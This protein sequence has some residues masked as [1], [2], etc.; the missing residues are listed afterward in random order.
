[1][2]TAATPAALQLSINRFELASHS[3]AMKVSYSPD[4]GPIVVEQSPKTPFVYKGPEGEL[5]FTETQ[6]TREDTPMGSLWSVVLT[7]SAAGSTTLS[8]FLPPI[9]GNGS[10]TITTYAVRTHKSG[11]PV[12]VGAGLT[13]EVERLKGDAEFIRFFAQ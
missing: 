10:H 3:G 7:Q 12:I 2:S 8:L 4:Q 13:Y 1:M 5:S 11:S 9:F 6:I